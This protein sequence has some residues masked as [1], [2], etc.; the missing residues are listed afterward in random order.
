VN[1]EILHV[2]IAPFPTAEWV[3]QQIVECCAW[4]RLPP[5]FLINDQ[6]TN[7]LRMDA[8]IHRAGY[9]RSV[10]AE[11]RDQARNQRGLIVG[12]E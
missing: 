12:V 7:M 1:R 6:N 8:A 9:E 2:A 5:Q 10:H 11:T 3:A 4:D